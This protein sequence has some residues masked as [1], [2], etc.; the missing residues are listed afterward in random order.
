MGRT[1]HG[2]LSV[3]EIA[4]LQ[5]GL[6]DLMDVF[7][8]R[9]WVMAYAA[10]GGNWELARYEWRESAKLLRQM[11]KTRPKYAED[12]AAFER[13]AFA[14]IGT[15]LEAGDL[16]ALEVAMRTAIEVSDT[17]H[18]KWS[19]GFIRF[20]LPSRPPDYLDVSGR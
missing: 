1:R 11:T 13:E 8:R 9:F 20:R 4:D 10:R 14:G 12:L 2:E 3:D 16:S 6:S 17:Y 19:K 15:A 7:G 18:E 5:H